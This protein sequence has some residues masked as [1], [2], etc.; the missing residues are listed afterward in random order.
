MPVMIGLRERGRHSGSKIVV[1]DVGRHD[2]VGLA[3]LDQAP[4]GIQFL[5]VPR[6]SYIHE[7]IVAVLSR[8]A[9]TWEML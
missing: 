4:V 5:F 6:F 2:H 9:V 7:A 3:I 1:V 8:T